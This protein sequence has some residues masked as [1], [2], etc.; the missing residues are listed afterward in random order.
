MVLGPGIT[1]GITNPCGARELRQPDWNTRRRN[2]NSP[3]LPHE[4]TAFV[5]RLVAD[6]GVPPCSF[7][8]ATTRH[9]MSPR[10]AIELTEAGRPG[11]VGHRHRSRSGPALANNFAVIRCQSSREQ[12]AVSPAEG[13]GDH[14][15]R[16]HIHSNARTLIRRWGLPRPVV[17]LARTR[18]LAATDV[19]MCVG[20]TSP[21]Y[22]L[23]GQEV[24]SPIR[25]CRVCQ[26]LTAWCDPLNLSVH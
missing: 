8:G 1:N 21:S 2:L 25:F 11:L 3:R 9:S 4:A 6:I 18:F 14:R 23:V 16:V 5:T 17:L 12:L 19:H 13:A 10:Q 22:H 26:G 15:S 24:R 20:Q 7:D